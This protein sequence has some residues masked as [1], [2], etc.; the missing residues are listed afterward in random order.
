M[1]ATFS[2]NELKKLVV[3]DYAVNELQKA[4]KKEQLA[5]QAAEKSHAEKISNL[6]A[7]ETT[8]KLLQKEIDSAELS[9]RSMREQFKHRQQQIQ[10]LIGAKERTALEHEITDIATKI[11]QADDS[12][13]LLLEQQDLIKK[14]ISQRK[15]EVTESENTLLAERQKRASAI[16]EIEKGKADLLM[17]SS[18]QILLVPENLRNEYAQLKQRVANPAAP[19]QNQSCSACFTQLLAQ[20]YTQINSRSVIRCRGCFR[21]LYLPDATTEHLENR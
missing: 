6:A 19:I 12:L 21:Y 15:A 17:E 7:M 3:I 9:G 16:A 11:D 5:G 13:M 18:Q 8:A 4:L 1:T 10:S 20:E 2:W 14:S